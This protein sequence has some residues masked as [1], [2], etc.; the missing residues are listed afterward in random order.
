MRE[1]AG[2]IAVRVGAVTALAVDA[3]VTP[4]PPSLGVAGGIHGAIH[5]AAGPK[6]REECR[7]IG[8]C[9]VG[10]ARITGGYAL[11]ARWVIHAVPPAW[12]PGDAAA[13]RLLA[14]C[15]TEAL[16]LAGRG[17]LETVAFA[18]LAGADA[19]GERTPGAAAR[20]AAPVAVRAVGA[21]LAAQPWPRHVTFCC[22]SEAEAAA[23]RA[24]LARI[25]GLGG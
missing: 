25:A 9:P 23:Y 13:G 7:A 11:P 22:A 20:A 17:E 4:A 10:E 16:R 24:L 5:R 18:P 15:Y 8:G 12:R 2:R 21:W 14:A 19:D 1:V 3:I 6:L